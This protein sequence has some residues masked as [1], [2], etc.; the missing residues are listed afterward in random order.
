MSTPGKRN[1]VGF[2]STV[3]SVSRESISRIVMLYDVC[4]RREISAMGR[5]PASFEI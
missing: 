1:E 2:L 3:N 4:V 5:K